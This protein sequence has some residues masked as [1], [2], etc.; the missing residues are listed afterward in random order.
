MT[1]QCFLNLIVFLLFILLPFYW[2]F[3]TSLRP[4][5]EL[6]ARNL[7]FFPQKIVFQHYKEL[8]FNTDFFIWFKNSWFVAS[9]TTVI[10]LAIGSLGA[11]S[12]VRFQYIG[13]EMILSRP[14][15]NSLYP[16]I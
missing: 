10:S 12:L 2:M 6:Y 11:Y 7:H 3:V 1:L 9:A 14:S 5:R 8:F 13:G 16:I 4:F 15:N